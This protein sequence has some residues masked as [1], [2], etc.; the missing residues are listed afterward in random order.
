MVKKI[1]KGI[2]KGTL[3]LMVL[4]MIFFIFC[5]ISN[6]R[7]EKNMADAL[8]SSEINT[9]REIELAPGET[10]QVFNEKITGQSTDNSVATI[11]DM[12]II[13]AVR[14]GEC[15]ISYKEDKFPEKFF[16][17]IYTVKVIVSSEYAGDDVFTVGDRKFTPSDIQDIQNSMSECLP[18]AT[19]TEEELAEL[20]SGMN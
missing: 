10:K 2:L 8:E 20:Y 9:S 13:S 12:G 19:F 16:S 15:Y 17:E 7:A 5:T 11:S 1:F 14:E 3:K 18:D 4:G 6:N